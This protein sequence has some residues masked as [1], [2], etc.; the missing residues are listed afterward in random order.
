MPVLFAIG[1]AADA[2]HGPRHAPPT[3]VEVAPIVAR[4]AGC[5]DGTGL[6]IPLRTWREFQAFAPVIGSVVASRTMPPWRAG[7]G[8]VAFLDDPSLTDDEIATVTA[9][10]DADGPLGDGDP[11]A[12]LSGPEPQAL[13]DVDVTLRMDD[14]Y[15]PTVVP[16][17]N[18]CFVLDRSAI[19][20]AW[21]TGLRI[22]PGAGSGAH[23]MM[24]VAVTPTDAENT[25][26]LA[27]AGDPGPGFACKPE[28]TGGSSFPGDYVQLGGWL[29]G[30]G[31]E[32]FPDGVGM[33]LPADATVILKA[34]YFT[35]GSDGA[36]DW[37]RVEFTLADEV[38][39]KAADVKIGT[40][41]WSRHNSVAVPAGERQRHTL[42]T[43]VSGETDALPEFH[44]EDGVLVHWVLL[45]MH[46]TGVSAKLEV[47]RGDETLTLLDIPRWDYDWQLEYWLQEPFSLRPTDQLRLSCLYDNRTDQ[48]VWWGEETTDEMCVARILVSEP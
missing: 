24:L 43:T 31:A 21:V 7:P 46:T 15:V 34:H 35:P 39:R 23:H 29:P 4:C 5:H 42:T 47:I 41:A 13:D 38:D 16:D 45:H 32:S 20:D 22:R 44:D 10:A 30:R 28:E 37:S 19:G 3:W 14:G 40:S 2:P 1:C 26:Q 12:L 9:W 6:T 27:D 36:P 8:D 11:D 25:P 48:D 17:D 33:H 18:R